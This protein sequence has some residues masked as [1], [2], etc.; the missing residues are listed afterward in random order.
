MKLDNVSDVDSFFALVLPEFLFEFFCGASH[1][2]FEHVFNFLGCGW[3]FN[4]SEEPVT[5]V[6][7]RQPGQTGLLHQRT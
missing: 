7:V 2:V 5:W 6:V 4:H 3:Y 1:S